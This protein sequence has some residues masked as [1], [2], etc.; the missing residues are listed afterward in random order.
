MTSCKSCKNPISYNENKGF[1]EHVGLTP[2][3]IAIPDD[4]DECGGCEYVEKSNNSDIKGR[5]RHPKIKKYMS[6]TL[7]KWPPPE[8]PI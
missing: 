2:R 1:W 3:H 8:C 7:E 6:V 4:S 5:C